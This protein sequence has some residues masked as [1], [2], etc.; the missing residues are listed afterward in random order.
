VLQASQLRVLANLLDD[1]AGNLL[2]N[3]HDLD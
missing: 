3:L 2:Q 1:L